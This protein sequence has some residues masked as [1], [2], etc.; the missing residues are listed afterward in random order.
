LPYTPSAATELTRF[1]GNTPTLFRWHHVVWSFTGAGGLPANTLTLYV[2]GE[3][4]NQVTRARDVLRNGFGVVIGA[5]KNGAGYTVPGQ[6]GIA[7]LRLHSG[8]LSGADVSHN[9]MAEQAAYVPTT[10]PTP[11]NTPSA[12]STQVTSMTQTPSNPP[13]PSPS[14]T[15]TPTRAPGLGPSATAL[16]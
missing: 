8:S 9:W 13:T 6:L 3:V 16:G 15:V 4:N 7:R 1:N 5:F 11:S 10:S 12:S 2:D 14:K